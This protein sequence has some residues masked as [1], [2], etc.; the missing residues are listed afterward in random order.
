MDLDLSRVVTQPVKVFHLKM[1]APTV[2]ILS[3]STDVTFE[4]I[5][6]PMSRAWYLQYYKAVG[7]KNNWLD[8]FIMPEEELLQKINAP[9]VA[10]FL[11]RVDNEVAGFLELVIERNFVELLYFGLFPRFIGKGLGKYFLQWSIRKAWSFDPEWIQLNTCELDH[12]NALPTYKRAGFIEY[13][14]TIEQRR[15]LQ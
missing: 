5:G 1:E 7:F 14:T 6:Q 4:R 3:E 8:R 9:N 13:K 10:I 11:M 2:G 12:E 15:V